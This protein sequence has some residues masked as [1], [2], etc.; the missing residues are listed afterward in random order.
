MFAL[1]PMTGSGFQPGAIYLLNLLLLLY[2]PFAITR[3][4]CAWTLRNL[5]Y[6]KLLTNAVKIEVM[7][8]K[9]IQNW[10]LG[11]KK[12]KSL[13]KQNIWI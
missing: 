2:N 8:C 9:N 12:A 3:A 4:I 7:P 11:M 6:E 10:K 1:R 5:E 13:E